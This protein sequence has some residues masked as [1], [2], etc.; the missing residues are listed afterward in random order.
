[1]KMAFDDSRR[2]VGIIAIIALLLVAIISI[3]PNRNNTKPASDEVLLDTNSLYLAA[4]QAEPSPVATVNDQEISVEEFNKLYLARGG[5]SASKVTIKDVKKA[6]VLKREITNNLIIKTLIEQ[7][8]AKHK[9]TVDEKEIDARMDALKKTF[10]NPDKYRLHIAQ[11]PGGEDYLRSVA[12]SNIFKEKLVDVMGVRLEASTTKAENTTKKDS[13]T[14][15][16]VR[17]AMLIQ[18][19]KAQAKISNWLE[20]RH[21]VMLRQTQLT[22]FPR[23]TIKVATNLK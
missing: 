5:S 11:I 16:F 12:R 2:L 23:E 19:L 13:G 7:A 3:I 21:I 17:N 1:M 18:Q 20:Q 15:Q 8:A 6:L 22:G 14:G 10:P 4:V 9:V